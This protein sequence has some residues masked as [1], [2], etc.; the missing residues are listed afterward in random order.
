MYSTFQPSYN[1]KYEE[2][3]FIMTEWRV[4]E[5]FLEEVYSDNAEPV[6]ESAEI[7]LLLGPI[8]GGAIGTVIGRAAG[9]AIAN[10]ATKKET[11]SSMHITEFTPNQ[12]SVAKKYCDVINEYNR[13][14]AI[15]PF[16]PTLKTSGLYERA[17][18]ADAKYREMLKDLPKHGF[19]S[20]SDISRVIKLIKT[21]SWFSQGIIEPKNLKTG[22]ETIQNLLEAGKNDKWMTALLTKLRD[23]LKAVSGKRVYLIITA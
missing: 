23:A 15:N 7:A 8:I 4:I 18:E 1:V 16:D 5:N 13:R 14:I 22:L 20:G 17:K 12:W 11:A 2:A 6:E 21:Y 9:N 10:H 19:I 3:A